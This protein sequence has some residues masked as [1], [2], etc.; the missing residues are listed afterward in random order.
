MGTDF[1][2]RPVVEN[3]MKLV[4]I[5]PVRRGPVKAAYL[6]L[7]LSLIAT[8]AP[9]WNVLLYYLMRHTAMNG[10]PKNRVITLRAPFWKLAGISNKAR[11]R[12]VLD[13]MEKHVP[14]ELCHLE[15][16][17]GR[18]AR[19]ILGSDWPHT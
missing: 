8:F 15:R 17:K 4:E 18:C 11:R 3:G 7:E 6:K 13:L 5:T 14:P 2:E 16:R 9:D 10:I 19:V 1:T 12:K